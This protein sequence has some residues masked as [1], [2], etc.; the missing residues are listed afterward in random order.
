MIDMKTAKDKNNEEVDETITEEKED[1][2]DRNED[3][4]G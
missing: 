3:C 4:R 2:H 1:N